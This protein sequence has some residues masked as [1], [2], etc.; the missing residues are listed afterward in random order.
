MAIL[1]ARQRRDRGRQAN[2]SNRISTSEKLG[3][4]FF[5]RTDIHFAGNRSNDFLYSV[6]EEEV[7]QR[8]PS[9]PSSCQ[10]SHYG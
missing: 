2:P 4:A 5:T 3:R 7:P 8:Y 6:A 1:N 9:P 10:P